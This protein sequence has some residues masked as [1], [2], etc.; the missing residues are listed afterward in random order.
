MMALNASIVLKLSIS[1]AK[2]AKT[3]K[4]GAYADFVKEE[5]A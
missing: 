4:Y 2:L 1:H 3:K 5:I